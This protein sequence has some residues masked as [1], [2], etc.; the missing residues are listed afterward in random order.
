ML[1]A[2][3]LFCTIIIQAWLSL[4]TLLSLFHS[5]RQHNFPILQDFFSGSLIYAIYPFTFTNLSSLS[6]F[7]MYKLLYFS[8]T[9]NLSLPFWLYSQKFGSFY[10]FIVLLFLPHLDQRVGA[11][12]L[13]VL[14][15]DD[16]GCNEILFLAICHFP[17]NIPIP[18]SAFNTQRQIDRYKDKKERAKKYEFLGISPN[19]MT[20]WW[21]KSYIN[22]NTI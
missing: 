21:S 17:S 18:C 10:P 4:F 22:S 20:F 2:A 11:L 14:L 1:Y 6:L 3:G 13:C 8:R 7:L 16:D 12:Y 19:S 15:N 5:S 9:W